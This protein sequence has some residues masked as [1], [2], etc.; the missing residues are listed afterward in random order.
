MISGSVDPKCAAFE[1][2]PEIV[3][4]SQGYNPP[5]IQRDTNLPG[6]DEVATAKVTFSSTRLRKCKEAATPGGTPERANLVAGSELM[7]QRGV[8][9]MSKLSKKACSY[10]SVEHASLQ[11][12]QGDVKDLIMELLFMELVTIRAEEKTVCFLHPNNPSLHAKKQQDMLP[13]FQRIHTE[14]MVFDQSITCFK[15]N[16]KEKCKR[17]YNV[18]FC[19]GARNQ[20]RCY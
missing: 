11:V 1:E 8:C 18:S 16:I 6:T 3:E 2:V 4:H 17:T 7:G 13:K 20:P 15:N 12:L 5:A 14:W 9:D 19:Q 10:A